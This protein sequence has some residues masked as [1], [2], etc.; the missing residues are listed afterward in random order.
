MPLVTPQIGR[1][2][3]A[4]CGKEAFYYLCS[5]IYSWRDWSKPFFENNDSRAPAICLVHAISALEK[6]SHLTEF[7]E[8]FAKVRLVEVV[9]EG[10]DGR[11]RADPVAIINLINGLR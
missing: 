3:E 2:L 1:L 10:K 7:L 5:L 11:M 9:D 6:R 4:V 8:C